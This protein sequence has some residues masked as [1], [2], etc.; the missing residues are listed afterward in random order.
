MRSL[1]IT[2]REEEDVE[3]VIDHDGGY[4]HDT[5]AH[6][7]DWHFADPKF[8]DVELTEVEEQAIYEECLDY[9]RN[10]EGDYYEY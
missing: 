3:I 9:G 1:F 8:K 4:E 10:D 2:F 5:G 7:I 6:V